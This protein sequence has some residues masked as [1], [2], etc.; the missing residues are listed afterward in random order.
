MTQCLMSQFDD[1]NHTAPACTEMLLQGLLPDSVVAEPSQ[2]SHVSMDA[3]NTALHEEVLRQML[4]AAA[5]AAAT[6]GADIL[7]P[8]C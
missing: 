7:I 1:L 4:A 6:A 8:Q 3:A 2:L 5:T